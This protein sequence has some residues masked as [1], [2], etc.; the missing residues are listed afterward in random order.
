[1]KSGIGN[2]KMCVLINS[3]TA[4]GA[5]KVVA[6]LYPQYQTSGVPVS[7]LSLERNDFHTIEGVTPVYF[8][9]Q[10]GEAEGGIKKLFSLFRFALKLKKYIKDNQIDLVQSH[11]YRSNYVNVLARIFGA[12]HKVQLVNHGMPSQYLTE[13]LAGKTNLWLIK[14]LYPKADQVICPSQ[15]MVDQFIALGV[16]KD[17]SQLIRNPFDL[18]D[19]RTQ[20]NQEMHSGEFEFEP[21]KQYL[22]AIGRLL[23]VKRMEDVIW[24]FY[25]LQKDMPK[26]ELI[27]L[28]DGEKRAAMAAL[29]MQLA[30]G[31]KVHMQGDV[32]NPHKYL[33]RSDVLVS[34][35][36][37]EGFSN[38]IVEALVAGTPVIS[39]DCESG[40][41]EILAPGTTREEKIAPSLVQRVKHGLLVPVGD[42][43]AMVKAMKQ[44]LGD[45]S[46]QEQLSRDGPA[47]VEE[48]DKEAIAKK[49][50]ECSRAVVGAYP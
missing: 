47:R 20:A 15:G 7:F 44:L 37:F 42:I 12:K 30:I 4:G 43:K 35:S 1:M 9:N 26:A 18:E 46:L 22:I 21:Q 13:G 5:E 31:K 33:V 32:K 38:V 28:G 40:P 19:L 49:Y 29:I 8:S 45:K 11:I 16:S 34:A 17:K 14:R 6:T 23:T 50:L 25:E 48:F 27:F 24:A 36:E 39:T 10:T 41:R 3:M 2:K